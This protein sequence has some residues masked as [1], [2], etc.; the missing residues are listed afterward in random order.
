MILHPELGY[1]LTIHQVTAGRLLEVVKPPQS[2]SGTPVQAPP[3][4]DAGAILTPGP[5]STF[6]YSTQSIN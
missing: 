5:V 3:A 1:I 4:F 6:I 2:T